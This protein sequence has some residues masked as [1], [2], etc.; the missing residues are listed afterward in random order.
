MT[1]SLS[2]LS[3]DGR[4]KTSFARFPAKQVSLFRLG[5]FPSCVI[6]HT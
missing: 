4:I 5:E 2:A 1:V 6:I 3:V